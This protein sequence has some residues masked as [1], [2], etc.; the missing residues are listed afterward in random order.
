MENKPQKNES[1]D[2]IRTMV[3]DIRI[4]MLTTVNEEGDLVC[5][6]MAAL[7]FDQDGS[8]WFF[9]NRS[10][11]KVGHIKQNEQRVNVSFASVSDANYVSISGIA[12]EVYD[13]AKIDQLWNPQAKAWFPKGKDDPELTLLKVHTQMAEYWDS[14]DSMMVRLFQ[15]ASAV[16]T[17]SVP[18][19]GE[20]EKV[21][22]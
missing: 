13:R 22:N 14:N 15:Q 3:E 2:K 16:L 12:S 11:P 1:M 4:A 21:Y 17:G 5:R 9:T 8:V 19:M 10:S 7:E 20:N 18:K 6:P